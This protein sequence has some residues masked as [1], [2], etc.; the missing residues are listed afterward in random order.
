MRQV[1]VTILH[2]HGSLPAG[3]GRRHLAP[4]A[5]IWGRPCQSHRRVTELRAGREGDSTAAG[6]GVKCAPALGLGNHDLARHRADPIGNGLGL[7]LGRSAAT[8]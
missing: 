3:A 6:V 5:R 8:R 1:A 7:S 4:A 2:I